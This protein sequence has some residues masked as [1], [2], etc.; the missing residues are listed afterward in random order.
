MFAHVVSGLPHITNISAS[1]SYPGSPSH[2]IPLAF[3]PFSTPLTD[4]G[5]RIWG[6]P[7]HHMHNNASSCAVELAPGYSY[8]VPDS[9][10]D[11]NHEFLLRY[12]PAA[13]VATDRTR[14]F[15]HLPVLLD[16]VSHGTPGHCSIHWDSGWFLTAHQP[17]FI[18]QTCY[19][20]GWR[21][22]ILHAVSLRLGT[23][24]WPITVRIDATHIPL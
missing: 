17:I 4:R 19:S 6:A 16:S 15:L 7:R 21:I 8:S 10:L 18:D 20:D 9:G 5:A 22:S 3:T 24:G 2:A 23:P 1:T 11:I 13:L 12:L 14:E